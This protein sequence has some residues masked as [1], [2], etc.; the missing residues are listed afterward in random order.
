MAYTDIDSNLYGQFTLAQD[1]ILDNANGSRSH[2]DV[3]DI[4]NDGKPDIVAG[5]LSGGISIYY[6]NG[7]VGI[8]DL[9]SFKS[10]EGLEIEVFPNP[11][12]GSVT[13]DLPWFKEGTSYIIEVY[14]LTGKLVFTNRESI[15]RTTIDL[16][17]FS[18]GMYFIQVKTEAK[19]TKAAKLIMQ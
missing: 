10:K 14:N 16:N 18:K 19:Q 1:N 9:S 15:A 7:F 4:N 6:G 17:T 3:A 13:I 12:N 2:I 11:T 5:N 8:D